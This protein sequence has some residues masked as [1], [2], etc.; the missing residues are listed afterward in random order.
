MVKRCFLF[1]LSK[2]VVVG[3]EISLYCEVFLLELLNVD[4]DGFQFFMP[5]IFLFFPLPIYI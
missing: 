2:N 5:L 3:D 1:A 4:L